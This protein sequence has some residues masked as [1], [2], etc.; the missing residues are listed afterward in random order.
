MLRMRHAWLIA[1]VALGLLPDGVVRAAETAPAEP[2][3]PIEAVP[4]GPQV[5]PPDA[6][7]DAYPRT[8]G[9]P[10]YPNARRV[11][12]DGDLKMGQV[13]IDAMVFFT[14][15]DV[16]TVI[17]YYRSNLEGR[18]LRVTEHHFSPYS[19]YVGFYHSPT[20]TMRLATV[21]G[22]AGGGCMIV[23]SA[24]NPVPL[25]GRAMQIP[26]DLPALP[27][28]VDVVTSSTEQGSKVHRTVYF[29]AWGRPD[30]VLAEL[31]ERGAEKGWQPAPKKRRLTDQGLTLV[32]GGKTCIIRALPAESSE[33]N[34]PSSAVTMV[35][36]EEKRK[37]GRKKR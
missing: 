11:R 13:P 34:N 1:A 26:E 31:A 9:L 35:V 4:P 28:A 20:Q 25:M 3:P 6:D 7:E 5:N 37:Q 36:I 15:D 29:E 17:D 12:L 2:A 18:K 32:Q 30:E 24:M 19:A 16:D 14:D 27:S 22:K 23:L 21:Q 10:P 33:A 8:L